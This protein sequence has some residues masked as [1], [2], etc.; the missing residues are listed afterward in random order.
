MVPLNQPGVNFLSEV[1][2]ERM[3]VGE[4]AVMGYHIRLNRTIFTIGKG[5]SPSLSLR[6]GVIDL[7]NNNDIE[8]LEIT[9]HSDLHATA[10]TSKSLMRVIYSEPTE[11][12]D[13]NGQVE[14]AI[15]VPGQ[16]YPFWTTLVN[17]IPREVIFT[18]VAV[19]NGD[20][21][22]EQYR[23]RRNNYG[24]I[25][26]NVVNDP[27]FENV[28]VPVPARGNNGNEPSSNNGVAGGRRRKTRRYKKKG[29]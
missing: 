28:N 13:G 4:F 29:R 20:D 10:E 6:I 3:S 5:G 19:L 2:L 17:D 25:V 27:G 22:C 1:F 24:E 14:V 7:G 9:I 23:I 21:H 18:A 16:T 15:K 12:S 26:S 11:Y 8:D